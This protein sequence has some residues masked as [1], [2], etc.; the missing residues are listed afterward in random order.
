[1]KIEE[2][3]PFAE[4]AKCT[5]IAEGNNSDDVE[6]VY[7][8][9]FLDLC[10]GR[11]FRP[12]TEYLADCMREKLE[13]AK[14]PTDPI[15]TQ[16]FA[17]PRSHQDLEIVARE[18]LGE[19]EPFDGVLEDCFERQIAYT[20][21]SIIES[22]YRRVSL[23]LSF[24][25]APAEVHDLMQ[26]WAGEMRHEV[27]RTFSVRGRCTEKAHMSQMTHKAEKMYSAHITARALWEWECSPTTQYRVH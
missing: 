18:M 25:Y 14:R 26:N 6:D 7:Q 13:R 11:T 12:S 15:E 1:V 16:D 5:L 22:L 9:I 23:M 20:E 10:K 3:F 17:D 8:D 4:K 21:R 19:I 2:F 27:R 24:M